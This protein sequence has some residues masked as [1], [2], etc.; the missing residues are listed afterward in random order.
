MPM[1]GKYGDSIARRVNTVA[2]PYGSAMPMRGKYGDSIA[3]RV[4][5]VASTHGSAMPMRGKSATCRLHCLYTQ[6]SPTLRS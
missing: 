3:R 1:R 4:N 2:S 5:T 6:G